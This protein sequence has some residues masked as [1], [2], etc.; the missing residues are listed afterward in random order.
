GNPPFFFGGPMGLREGRM[1]NRHELD[2]AAPANPVC[3]PA[4]WGYWGQPPCYS[5]LNSQALALNR[6]D[7]HTRPRAAGVEIEKVENGEP[8]GV[9]IDR[10]YPEAALLDLLPEVPRFSPDERRDAI[11]R[12]LAMFH[13]KGTTS[14]YEGHGTAP[15]LVN[16]YRELHQ[17]NELRM[18]MTL[19]ANPVL[20]SIPEADRMYRDWLAHA[21][22]S[23]MGDG[24]LRVSGVH[25]PYGGDPAVASLARQDPSDTN[26]G[27]Y[28]AQA[29][30]PDEFEH[31][32]LL[33]AKHD[34]RLH[35]IASDFA[36]QLLPSLERVAAQVPIAGKRWVVE[37]L[38]ASS[39]ETVARLKRL[40]VGVTLIPAFHVWKVSESRDYPGFSDERQ[41]YV[42]PARQLLE[43]GIPVAAGTDGV[44]HDPL[45]T[46]WTMVNRRTRVEG[47]A[48]GPAGRADVEQALR[49]MT[50]AGAWFSFEENVKG[51]LQPGYFADLAVLSEDP[52]AVAPERLRELECLA[53][54]VGGTWVHGEHTVFS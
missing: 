6:I 29:T 15:A 28:V 34:L 41:A 36:E 37:H 40:G 32:A 22:G 20:H 16:L 45:F 2:Q 19:V 21:R 8:T 35:T 44:P 10:N 12:A 30:A 5:A 48:L 11:R 39:P 51:R 49:L 27:G 46:I 43:A 31:L 13:S 4:P 9:I 53:T 47:Q 50:T 26:W 17:A 42:A 7:R 1:P 23:G 25:I 33:A 14:I 24:W 3:I 52:T 38:G 18:R 54:M